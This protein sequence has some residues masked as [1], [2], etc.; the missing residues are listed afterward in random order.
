MEFLLKKENSKR[1]KKQLIY[2]FE[3]N[4]KKSPKEK[5]LSGDFSSVVAYKLNNFYEFKAATGNNFLLA[6][7]EIET[8]LPL[9]HFIP[10][11]YRW[12]Y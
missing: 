4:E 12:Q 7:K 2:Q 11:A 9:P 6:E 1:L 10:A 8:A 3:L 5:R